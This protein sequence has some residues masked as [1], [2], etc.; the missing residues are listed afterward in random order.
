MHQLHQSTLFEVP[1]TYPAGFAY[2]PSFL[3]EAEETELVEYIEDLPLTHP[4]TS[5][6]P[7][8]RRIINFGWSYDFKRDL[9][10]EGPALPP[11][12]HHIARRA[13]KWVDIKNTR[14]VE[15]LITE[16][17]AGASI[18][19]H[20]DNERF[21]HIIGISLL[22]GAALRLRPLRTPT[23]GPR[24]A[25]DIRE[26]WLAPRSIYVLAHESRWNFQHAIPA[27]STLRY[28]I[29][30]RTLPSTHPH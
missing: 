22:G 13:A 17:A 6:Y 24:R 29:T 5:G 30:F 14:I 20:R 4:L 25:K 2:R 15:A 18:G 26:C 3:T 8:K 12:L 7:A 23:D 1:S 16:Y 21:T 28:S 27:V 10:I 9:L 19:W 11:F